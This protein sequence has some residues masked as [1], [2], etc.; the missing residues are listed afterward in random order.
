MGISRGAPLL[1]LFVASPANAEEG[2]SSAHDPGMA[3]SGAVLTTVG[4]GA[5]GGGVAMLVDGLV[6]RTCSDLTQRCVETESE[7]KIIGPLAML[8]GSVA[9]AGGVLMMAHGLRH[10]ANGVGGMP[11]THDGAMVATGI[12]LTV[13]GTAGL[14]GGF[15]VFLVGLMTR[16]CILTLPGACQDMEIEHLATGPALMVGAATTA[17]GG[18]WMIAHGGR[19]TPVTVGAG[20]VRVSW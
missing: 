8:G 14:V 11:G 6:A 1:L 7:M 17:A 9:L 3:A 16:E 10:E 12:G 15:F 20:N 2:R 18:I 5:F 19:R 13:V 4:A